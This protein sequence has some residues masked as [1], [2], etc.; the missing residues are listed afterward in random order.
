MRKIGGGLGTQRDK[1]TALEQYKSR[2]NEIDRFQNNEK[3]RAQEL[4]RKE[5]ARQYLE[6][7]AEKERYLEYAEKSDDYYEAAIRYELSKKCQEAVGA[8]ENSVNYGEQALGLPMDD[9]A[10]T[11]MDSIIQYRKKELERIRRKCK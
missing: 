11:N 9:A 7:R 1:T 8:L 4:T 10:R 6:D 3:E 2:M 5:K